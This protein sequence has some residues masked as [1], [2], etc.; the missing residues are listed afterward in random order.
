MLSSLTA[1][2]QAPIS[3]ER[4]LE[5]LG[6]APRRMQLSRE[7]PTP[8][9]EPEA[10]GKD[11]CLTL[12]FR[13]TLGNAFE[14]MCPVETIGLRESKGRC[15]TYLRDSSWDDTPVRTVQEWLS[16]VGQYV[17]I[18]DCL[19]LSF[20]LNYDHDGGDPGRP[21]TDVGALRSRAKPY[22]NA[23]TDQTYAAADFLA[24]KLLVH[25]G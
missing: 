25:M 2:V 4:I 12:P 24:Q 6:W 20:A 13:E 17:A 21:Q 10:V 5:M 9:H 3:D 23:P 19:A 7:W 11:W 18:R 14:C 15:W 8:L 16:V 1:P 22:D